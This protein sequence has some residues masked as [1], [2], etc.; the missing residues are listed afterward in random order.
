MFTELVNDIC[1][2]SEGVCSFW[3][4]VDIVQIH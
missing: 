3:E 4:K 1:I 2:P